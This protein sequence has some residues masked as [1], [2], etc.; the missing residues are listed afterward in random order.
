MIIA[1]SAV[2][3][4]LFRGCNSI[5]LREAVNGRIYMGSAINLYYFDEV[6]YTTTV[7]QEY[8]L[9]TAENECK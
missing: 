1:S 6:N 5:T 3:V 8:D 2:F 4:L 9:A 7:S